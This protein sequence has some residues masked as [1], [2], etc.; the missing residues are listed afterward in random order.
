MYQFG[1]MPL[2]DFVSQKV[3]IHFDGIGAGFEIDIPD[4]FS[5][6]IL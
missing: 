3:N 6:F 4:F 1:M 5:D 2:V